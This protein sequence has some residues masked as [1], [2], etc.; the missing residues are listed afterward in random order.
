MPSAP[1]EVCAVCDLFFF[2]VNFFF[3]FFFLALNSWIYY[4]IEGVPPLLKENGCGMLRHVGW[5][6]HTS[7]W[8]RHP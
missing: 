3:F 8:A 1:K 4:N 5:F 2:D 6:Y 7:C